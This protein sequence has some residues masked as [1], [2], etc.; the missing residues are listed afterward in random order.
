[1][2]ASEHDREDRIGQLTVK[3]VNGEPVVERA[4]QYI[5]IDPELS[6]EITDPVTKTFAIGDVRYQVLGSSATH[7]PALIC[8][9]IA[10]PPDPVGPATTP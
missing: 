3:R 6:A 4:D 2:S 10:P 7:P 1:M 5:W 8:E 9:R